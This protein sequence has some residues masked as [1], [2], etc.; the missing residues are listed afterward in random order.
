MPTFRTIGGQEPSTVSFSLDV[1]QIAR[2]GSNVVREI[3][4]IGDPD[5]SN[6]NAAVLAVTPASSAWGLVVRPLFSSTGADNPVTVSNFSTTVSVANQVRVSNSTAGELLMRPVFSSTNTDNPVRAVLS[7][8]NTDNPVR[9][10]VSSTRS[11]N[12]VQ[13]GAVASTGLS[14]LGSHGSSVTFQADVYGRLFTRAG[15][16]PP[17]PLTWSVNHSPGAAAQATISKSSAAGVRQIVTGFTVTIAA[18]ST[19]PAAFHSTIALIDGA[20]AGTTYL[21]RTAVSLSSTPSGI[22]SYNFNNVWFAGAVA[23]PVTLEFTSSGPANTV[24]S[25]CMWGQTLAE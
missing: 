12:P 20:T 4:V 9:A 13:V 24:Q 16:Q 15:H 23:G 14:T 7:S 10:V 2:N 1:V 22:V 5:T 21:W 6:G 19:S 17:A 8:T 3:Q 25:V 11:D 18:T